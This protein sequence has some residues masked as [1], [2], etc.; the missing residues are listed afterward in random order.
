MGGEGR[1][2]EA[3]FAA[4]ARVRFRIVRAG[5][6]MKVS[7]PL[8]GKMRDLGLHGISLETSQIMADGL[9][10]SYDRHPAQRN[11]IYLQVQLPRLGAIR[12]VGE[13]VWYERIRP[14]ESDFVV[15]LRFVEISKEDKALL[16]RYLSGEKTGISV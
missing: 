14:G 1:R 5:P 11:R 15:G 9:H 16:S 7:E 2:R 3:R 10:I 13:T 12:A 6:D 4:K 8:E